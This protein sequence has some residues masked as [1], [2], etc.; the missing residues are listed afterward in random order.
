LDGS[1]FSDRLGLKGERK[2]S[3]NKGAGSRGEQCR[4][5]GVKIAALADRCAVLRRA[6]GAEI[7][8]PQ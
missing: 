5:L 2:A 6:Q 1:V 3:G 7:A 8:G 4:Y